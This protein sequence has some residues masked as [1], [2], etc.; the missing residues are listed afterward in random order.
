MYSTSCGFGGGGLK[1]N[2]DYYWDRQMS[3]FLGSLDEIEGAYV[4]VIKKRFLSAIFNSL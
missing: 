4:Q 3:V 2:R 1:S